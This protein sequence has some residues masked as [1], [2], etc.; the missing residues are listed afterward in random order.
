MCRALIFDSSVW[1]GMPS[2]AAP[3]QGPEIRPRDAASAA[4]I[5]SFSPSARVVTRRAIPLDR[6]SWFPLEPLLVDRERVAIAQHHGPLDHVLQLAHVPWPVVGLKQLHRLL[7]D[8]ADALPGLLGVALDQIFD[9]NGNVVHA[10]AQRGDPD[11][12][13][14]QAVVKILAERAARYGGFQGAG[15]GGQGPGN[16]RK[17]G[18][19]A[20]TP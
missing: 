11:R 20:P 18:A 8:G 10:L 5:S 16:A 6:S 3:P 14:I 15:R 12:K 17:R 9:Q 2:F 4:P 13:D 19:A 7:V 1:R